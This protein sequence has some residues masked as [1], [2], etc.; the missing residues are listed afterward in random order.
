MATITPLPSLASQ[1]Q[2]L[3]DWFGGKSYNS[4]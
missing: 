3:G 1:W 2:T 4:R